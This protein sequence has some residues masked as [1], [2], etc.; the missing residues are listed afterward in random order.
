MDLTTQDRHLMT[1][2]DDLKLFRVCRSDQKG[3][4]LQDPL[5]GDVKDGQDHGSPLRKGRYFMLIELTHPTG[6]DHAVR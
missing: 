1:E 6:S 3:D 2:H 4:Q 5:E